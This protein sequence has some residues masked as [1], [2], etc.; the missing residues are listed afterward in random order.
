V[1]EAGH[2]AVLAGQDDAAVAGVPV[3]RVRTEQVFVV[4]LES[5]PSWTPK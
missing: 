4:Q 1:A 5:S 3:V 2:T